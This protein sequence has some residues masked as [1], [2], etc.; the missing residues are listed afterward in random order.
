[1][2]P[3]LILNNYQNVLR[4]KQHL[5]TFWHVFTIFSFSVIFLPNSTVFVINKTAATMQKNFPRKQLKFTNT[6]TV[7]MQQMIQKEN[8]QIILSEMY[9]N[10]FQISTRTINFSV[11]YSYVICK[12]FQVGIFICEDSTLKHH[13]AESQNNNYCYLCQHNVE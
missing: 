12:L 5:M 3:H 8:D 7:N 6:L 1:M 10:K 9:R 11:Y 13:F 4:Q 2:T